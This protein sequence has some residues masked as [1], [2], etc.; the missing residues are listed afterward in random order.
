MERCG[1]KTSCN[2]LVNLRGSH[3][4]LGDK[5]FCSTECVN[6]YLAQERRLEMAIAPLGGQ[7]LHRREKKWWDKY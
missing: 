5:H 7:P 2:S 1:N 4:R 3:V 6:E